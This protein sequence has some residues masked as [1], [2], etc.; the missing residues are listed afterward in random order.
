MWPASYS[1][2]PREDDTGSKMQELKQRLLLHAALL[3]PFGLLYRI[4]DIPQGWYCPLHPVS[5]VIFQSSL[6]A[7][8]YNGGIPSNKVAS[9]QMIIA[10]VKYLRKLTGKSVYFCPNRTCSPY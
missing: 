1:P 4:A 6:P 10:C 9:S 5:D 8:Q 3:A 7:S 2:S